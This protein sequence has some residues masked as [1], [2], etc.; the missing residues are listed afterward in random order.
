MYRFFSL[1]FD[2]YGIF[3][4][5]VDSQGFT[6]MYNIQIIKVH[7]YVEPKQPSLFYNIRNEKGDVWGFM[8]IAFL[9]CQC[10]QYEGDG[11]TC[12]D[13]NPC[14]NPNFNAFDSSNYAGS[15]PQITSAGNQDYWYSVNGFTDGTLT[16]DSTYT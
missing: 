12:A 8:T 10:S 6:N 15:A 14:N 2:P 9:Y 16:Y 3:K 4:A 7:N 5:P 13:D 1:G 11:S